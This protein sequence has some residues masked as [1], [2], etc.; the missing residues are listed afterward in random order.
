MSTYSRPFS[1]KTDKGV[2]FSGIVTA[3]ISLE[4]LVDIISRIAPYQS[5][6]AFLMSKSGFSSR[7]PTR[8]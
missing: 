6:F 5:G 1:R 8:A 4:W 2:V 7:T 3:D